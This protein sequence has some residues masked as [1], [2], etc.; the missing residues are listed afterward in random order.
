MSRLFLLLALAAIAYFAYQLL[1]MRRPSSPKLEAMR[2][3]DMVRCE[4]CGIHLPA[5][6]SFDNAGHHYCSEEHLK[7]GRIR[8]R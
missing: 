1:M 3:Q 8:N 5:N 6:E 2:Q 7:L 4:H